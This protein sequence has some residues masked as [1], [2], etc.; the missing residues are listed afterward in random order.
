MSYA[1]RRVLDG[2]FIVAVLLPTIVAEHHSE[3]S[4]EAEHFGEQQEWRVR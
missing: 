1:S 3:A 2:Y 4:G